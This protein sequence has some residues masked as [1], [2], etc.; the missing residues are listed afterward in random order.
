MLSHRS[1]PSDKPTPHIGA[2][3]IIHGCSEIGELEGELHFAKPA[4]HAPPAPQRQLGLGAHQPGPEA[5][6]PGRNGRAP[7]AVQRPAQFAHEVGVAHGIGADGQKS[8]LHVL[9]LD[10]PEDHPI[11]VF[12]MQPTDPL[13]PVT[14]GPAEETARKPAQCAERAAPLTECK[15]DSQEHAP[16]DRRRRLLK[17]ALPAHA[18]FWREPRPGRR[19]LVEK[20]LAGITMDCRRCSLNPDSGRPIAFPYR[21][22]DCVDRIDARF[23]DFLSILSGVPAIHALAG[24]VDDR[25]GAVEMRLPRTDFCHPNARKLYRAAPLPSR[26]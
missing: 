23:E 21:A 16:R 6:G 26:A 2:K 3:Q 12:D 9:A 25:R 11:Q 13:S 18:R 4:R 7:G 20:P 10:R 15:P 17:G 22:S 1:C 19:S 24:E 5:H 14:N 8:S